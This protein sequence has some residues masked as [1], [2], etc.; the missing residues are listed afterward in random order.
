MQGLMTR[1]SREADP[2]H[3]AER[4]AARRVTA[5]GTEEMRTRE[6]GTL[7]GV[8]QIMPRIVFPPRSSQ[9]PEPGDARFM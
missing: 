3:S 4:W 2:G 8:V 9:E 1:F 5:S 6:R 7:N